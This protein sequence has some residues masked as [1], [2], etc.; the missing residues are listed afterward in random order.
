MWS[1]LGFTEETPPAESPQTTGSPD[2]PTPAGHDV[3]PTPSATEKIGPVMASSAA[4]ETKTDAPAETPLATPTSG[5]FWS[6][7]GDSASSQPATAAD[8][9]ALASSASPETGV[10]G[11]ARSETPSSPD[12]PTDASGAGESGRDEK[13]K[14]KKKKEK[15]E[16]DEAT[17][18]K[19]K[20][21]KV[22]EGDEATEKKKK[23]EKVEEGDEA[24][25]KKKKKEKVEEGDE[26]TEKK[27]KK[28][29]VE[30][31][32]EATEK[33]K[34]KDGSDGSPSKPVSSSDV[35]SFRARL[36]QL[37]QEK[38]AKKMEEK[39]KKEEEKRRREDE[40]QRMMAEK[41]KAEEEKQKRKER[42]RE[43][44]ER[45][46]KEKEA[47]TRAELERLAEELKR[48]QELAEAV[49]KQN[50]ERRHKKGRRSGGSS[51][52][53]S[54]SPDRLS[55]SR[56]EVSEERRKAREEREKKRREEQAGLEELLQLT[57]REL[58]DTAR[59]LQDSIERQIREREELERL[60][61]EQADR[62]MEIRHLA[63]EAARALEAHQHAARAAGPP[64]PPAGA[65]IKKQPPGGPPGGSAKG[66]SSAPTGLRER[67]FMLAMLKRDLVP[68]LP[69]PEP[70]EPARLPAS[71]PGEVSGLKDLSG[72]K[73]KAQHG[74]EEVSTAKQKGAATLKKAG[75]AQAEAGFTQGTGKMLCPTLA[76]REDTA[77]S[78]EELEAQ[79]IQQHVIFRGPAFRAFHELVRATKEI[80]RLK[81][82]AE[83]AAKE[84]EEEIGT[85]K[86]RMESLLDRQT[87]TIEAQF[88]RSSAIRHAVN[89]LDLLYKATQFRKKTLVFSKMKRAAAA[90][91]A[92]GT[93]AIGP[94]VR[95]RL[96]S[97]AKFTGTGLRMLCGVLQRHLRAAWV[98]WIRY[99]EAATKG[100]REASEGIRVVQDGMT[101]QAIM[102]FREI[103]QEAD[104]LK[105]YTSEEKRK[106]A[107]EAR[108][109]ERWR[110]QLA[111]MHDA[112]IRLRENEPERQ[113]SGVGEMKARAERSSMR[114]AYSRKL[115]LMEEKFQ[116]PDVLTRLNAL[117][118]SE[119]RLLGLRASYRWS[120]LGGSGGSD[121][122][123]LDETPNIGLFRSVPPSFQTQNMQPGRRFMYRES[124][125]SCSSEER[126]SSFLESK[127]TS[128]DGSSH[129]ARDH[130]LRG[131]PRRRRP[132]PEDSGDDSTPATESDTSSVSSR[133]SGSTASSGSISNAG[134]HGTRSPSNS[135][136]NGATGGRSP[137][138][139]DLGEG[140]IKGHA[141]E[142]GQAV[143]EETTRRSAGDG[144]R[145]ERDEER[146]KPPG[147]ATET[148]DSVPVAGKMDL[149]RMPSAVKAPRSGPSS[150]GEPASKAVSSTKG[151]SHACRIVKTKPKPPPPSSASGVTA[152]LGAQQRQIQTADS[153]EMSQD[154][155][156]GKNPSTLST[157]SGE[158]PEG[159]G[160][161]ARSKIIFADVKDTHAATKAK[162]AIEAKMQMERDKK[163]TA[164][165]VVGSG[166]PNLVP[167]TLVNVTGS[168][169]NPKQ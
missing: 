31:G 125:G 37:D 7:W 85:L 44:K 73:G 137:Y 136:K 134:S 71:A 26:A 144:K 113:D 15:V 10:S 135:E 11:D 112:V 17:E 42:E 38:K 120:G 115:D 81:Q 39:K 65:T 168:K 119:M 155:S 87:R 107:E 20:K 48:T 80:D 61:Q 60:R 156:A 93:A 75:H 91:G 35:D 166:P 105:Q 92:Q 46:K 67:S 104:A 40:K 24:T 16:G 25:E 21:E 106:L 53:G 41:K 158:E 121:H 101:A 23:K 109:L 58:T 110:R 83:A 9:Q 18:K 108:R 157:R 47:A 140:R 167:K 160:S 149:Q 146:E 64:P 111:A 29:K 74:D 131:R 79:C 5:G 90:A 55:Q 151:T 95:G 130:H 45:K 123:R 116:A 1:L 33:K 169:P 127:K 8:A 145:G 13:E 102:A 99:V 3:P 129:Y 153:L 147:T 152:G 114:Q 54:S 103:E 2:P 89:I 69:P 77:V 68:S 94:A 132:S 97:S 43:E 57:E 148:H 141:R 138:R 165:I 118:H 4:P 34:K 28:E 6:L 78:D 82:E 52:G 70:V 14:K 36:E 143:K 117:V 56:R 51:S 62:E 30:E 128:D 133:S 66:P 100:E 88:E 27:K 86:V 76:K 159:K 142:A 19:K 50:E 59:S 164:T 32:D 96:G 150:T 162:S 122:L 22:E 72:K 84:K 63:Q 161:P 124:S 49:E 139:E 12:A 98:Q 163:R 126:L 154:G